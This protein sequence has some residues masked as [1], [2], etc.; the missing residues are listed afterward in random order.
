MIETYTPLSAVVPEHLWPEGLF[1]ADRES[2][3]DHL[4]CLVYDARGNDER[5]EVYVRI[6]VMKEARLPLPFLDGF[7]LVLGKGDTFETGIV[8]VEMIVE[9][10]PDAPP[11]IVVLARTTVLSLGID[12]RILEPVKI[13]YEGQRLK[14]T[15][16]GGHVAVPFP[17]ALR[18]E[19]V[20]EEWS[21]DF[22]L[23]LDETTSLS[24]P[25]C[26]IT[27]TNV[28]FEAAG[29]SLNL[30][31]NG[32]SPAGA[33]P[34][35]KGFYL[36]EAKIYLPD[37]FDG[38]ISATALGIGSG[39]FYG[40]VNATFA[41]TYAETASPRFSGD[42]VTTLLG[43]EGGISSVVLSFIQN[44][45]TAA[46]IKGKLLVPFFDSPLDVRMGF[47]AG[48]GLTVGLSSDQELR[49]FTKENVCELTLDGMSFEV[50]DGLFT[51]KLSGKLTPLFGKDKG[52]KWPTFDIKDLTI[53]SKGNVKLPG[54]WLSL[55]QQKTFDFYG[56]KIEIS[57]IGF[58]KN[59]DGS[60][61]IGFSGALKLVDGLQAGASVEGLR[62][63]WFEG[64]LANAKITLN[65]AGVELKI[66]GVLELKGSVSYR[67][68]K[69]GNEDIKRFDGD[70]QLKIKTPEMTVDGMMVIGSAKGPQGRYNFFAIYVDVELPTAIMLGSTG[71]AIYN[72]AGLF[73]LQMEP[74]K[75]AEEKWFSIDHGKSFYHRNKPG[76]TDLR[77]KWDPRKG[78]FAFGAG[79]KIG[80][81]A[82]DGYTFNGKFLLAIVL[83]G[84][85]ILLQGAS[86]F[87]TKN[88]E[89]EGQFRSLAVYDGRA[90]SFLIG[91]DAE[92]KTGKG[93]ELIEIAGSMEAYYSL[94]D[95]TAWHLWLGQRDPRAL[96]IR[97]ILGKFVEANAYFMLDARQLALGAW[98]GYSNGWNVG[99][100]SIRLEAWAEG[101]ALISFKPTHFHGDLWLHALVDLRVF[102]F[103][104]GIALDARIEADLFKPY[105]LRGEF[106]V[107]VKLPFRKKKIGAKVVLEWG[108][109]LTAPPLPLPLSQ[110]AV[111][112]L[113]TTTVWPL[114]RRKDNLP[115]YLLPNYDD[116]GG[117]YTSPSGSTA[118]DKLSGVPLVPL[119]SRIS[120]TFARSVHDLANVGSNLQPVN[121]A[122]E[123]VGHPG[124]PVVARVQYSLEA[125]ELS[126]LEA[127]DTWK[128]VAKSPQKDSTP[129]LY[130]QWAPVP[131]L[132]PGTPGQTKL[133]LWSK[134]AFD[135]TRATGSSWEEWVSDAWP[136][137]PCIPFVPGEEACFGFAGLAA[138]AEVKSPWTYAG[139]PRV[140]LSW[141][142]GPATVRERQIFM[143]DRPFPVRSLCFP[144]EVARRGVHVKCEPGQSVKIHLTPRGMTGGGL[145]R[146]GKDGGDVPFPSDGGWP[147]TEAIW[148]S[149]S[150]VTCVDVREEIA[151]TRMNPWTQEDL[152][153]AV[154]GADGTLLPQAR[155]E[156]W[157]TSPLGLNAGHR[158]DVELPCASPWVELIVTHR[159]PFRIV[160]FNGAGTAV[161][162]HTPA[163]AGV[164]TT[165][166]IRLEGEGITRL[167][168][169]AAGNEKLIHSVCYQC[170]RPSGPTGTGHDDDGNP[171]G[172]FVP[173]D[174]VIE[175]TG[176]EVTDVVVTSDASFCIDRIC[177]TPDVDAGQVMGRA[178]M[179]EHIRQELARWKS[180][181]ELLEP[182]T[183]YRLTVRTSIRPTPVKKITFPS[184][185]LLPVEH[186]YFRTG[187]PPGITRLPPPE[188]VKEENFDSGLDDL[189]RYVRETDPPTVPPPGEKPI[190]YE[191]F[192][193][194]YDL[195]VEFN[196]AYVGQMYRMDGRDLGLYVYDNSNQPARDVKG[197]LLALSNEWGVAEELTLSEKDTRW[198]TRIDNA[199]CLEEKLDPETF[200]RS[201]ALASVDP[202]RVLAPGT[203]YEARLVPLLLH[204][205]FARGDL[206]DV[207][208]GWLVEDSGAGGPSAWRA[209]ELGEPASRFVEQVSA[210]GGSALLF[211]AS[212]DWTDYRVTVYVQSP[213]RGAIGVVVRHQGPGT[214]Y[215]FTMDATHL[216]LTSGAATLREEHFAYQKNR[217]Y[218]LSVEVLGDMVRTYVD[219]EAVFEV[220]DAAHAQ[221]RIGL[222]VSGSAGARFTDVTVD[223]LRKTAPVAYRY[224]FTT[225][226]YANF[227][228][229]VHS[230]EDELWPADLATQ[231]VKTQLDEAIAPILDPPSEREARAYDELATLVLGE[232]VARQNPERV[233]IT[234]VTRTG[235]PPVYLLRSPE[236]IDHR[237][238]QFSAAR[239]FRALPAG[240][241][242][243]TLKLAEA[244]LDAALPADESVTLLLRD[245]AELTRHRVELRGLP[246]P[247]AEQV[248][249]PVLWVETFTRPESLE[250]FTFA[251]A[252]G[253]SAWK[254][255]RGAIV[256][257]S[258]T[259][260]GN[261]P[262]QPGTIAL[263][264]DVEWQDYRVTVDL[265][266]DA[267][268]DVGVVFRHRDADNHYRFSLGAASSY[269]RLVRCAGGVTTVLWEDAKGYT[270]G[271]TFRVAIVAIASS[272][273][274]FVDDVEIFG[275]V[276][277]THGAGR[278][279]IYAANNAGARCE[280]IEVRLPSIEAR[281]LF[282]D[283]FH[284]GDTAEWT[285]LS[286]ATGVPLAE[287]AHWQI[288]N[289]ALRLDS[290]VA[291]GAYA[292]AGDSSWADVILQARVRSSGGMAGVLIRAKDPANGYRFSMSAS[293]ERQLVRRVDG[294]TTI[295]WRDTVAYQANRWYEVTISAIGGTLRGFID[296]IPLFAVDDGDLAD[297]GVGLFSS[298][299][300]QA[301]F[302]D[303]HVWPGTQAFSGWSF[304]EH[305]AGLS[306]DRWSF[307]GEH[308]E[309][310]AD[311]WNVEDG[312]LR[313]ADENVDIL[314]VF[315]DPL[316]RPS[317]TFR[318]H[319]AI[320]A[321]PE[322]AGMRLLARLRLDPAGDAG[323]VF[324][325]R[326]AF[327]HTVLWL[328][329]GVVTLVR[330]A[331]GN[332]ETLVSFGLSIDHTTE[333]VVAIDCD[334]GRIAASIDG[335]VLFNFDAA[336]SAG[337]FGFAVMALPTFIVAPQQRFRELL[338]AEPQWTTLY[339]FPP[340]ERLPAGTRVHVHASSPTTTAAEAGRVTRSVA[341]AGERGRTRMR[342]SQAMLRLVGPDGAS[343]HMRGFIH[344]AG[345]VP[346]SVKLL[347][348]ADG[349]AFFLIPEDGQATNPLRVTMT[350]HRDRPEAGRAMSQAGDRGV[351]QGTVVLR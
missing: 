206:A 58:G 3:L 23:P 309:A 112:H 305:F 242:P 335:G 212:A 43:M 300:Q 188:G 282:R 42:L 207:P 346:I 107:G 80:T 196:E 182:H 82:D 329:R 7:A 143:E 191:P 264:G 45:P 21:L 292:M 327:N 216:R 41:L 31:G 93:G 279:G 76:I 67:E 69:I 163:A 108:P 316:N 183:T 177:V 32:A 28:I 5:L 162:T 155:I 267:G 176:D 27:D 133:M 217:D 37:L 298:S 351:E 73:A 99:P 337:R 321:G 126:R 102:G 213:V 48:G 150:S 326:D 11:S 16:L 14:V 344:E 85:I 331:G 303:V 253:P 258:G 314:N 72:I 91:L 169:H 319:Y 220:Q 312:T 252:A 15:P 237:R 125:L 59:D 232:P 204:E 224:Q 142:F 120:V 243:Q 254:W 342:G 96:R 65:G 193:R 313:P 234:R 127:N 248:G 145:R 211:G 170:T 255:E 53:D 29:V 87:L 318:A 30:S 322:I 92:Y 202:D 49:R 340:E 273:T 158:L 228:H 241:P 285:L 262:E 56:F 103:G 101:N 135:F 347:R 26:R 160:A 139:P 308:G 250:R 52:L 187:G 332:A 164:Q 244:T 291:E 83:P 236:P 286:E 219:G 90:G 60:K 271:E 180:T 123:E 166:T 184:G 281:A 178:E 118:P 110:V 179:I 75:K 317:M 201:S 301:W 320:A 117:F 2:F 141:G 246:G 330:T 55:A 151:G 307:V 289:G 310:E 297:G 64:D 13:E 51:T 25:P 231:D 74:N 349:T 22:D 17:F 288:D 218:R 293:G 203:L 336:L 35:W 165:E 325:W 34:G 185:P 284:R 299:N 88:D 124:G 131:Q 192:Y 140:T 152:R 157:G 240:E 186:A 24:I 146:R 116:G 167:E 119:D 272:I 189:V 36:G 256:E 114:P 230:F 97:A 175:V 6:K 294:T 86:S 223:D 63:T 54:G 44:I 205:T 132:G 171:Y 84:P 46:A 306:A 122:E 345:W 111:E 9:A 261:E 296:G 238:T 302:S 70:I 290:L 277:D 333:H 251:D 278:V 222:Y 38:S 128:L 247:V 115:K 19:Y 105:H 134:S 71:L 40:S 260:G 8:D 129:P 214:G 172:P 239:S 61:W 104:F 275:V 100:L 324:G 18:L 33:P 221:G 249:D 348:K 263:A 215:R 343:G 338:L 159:P 245:S 156:R 39:G 190:L 50:N 323:I 274:A 154:R 147:V 315:R 106:S 266:G 339:A 57:Q 287:A 12:D 153:F 78:S 138:G 137:Y 328:G 94:H 235:A 81:Y 98:F 295:L 334:G 173:V 194:A 113:K 109:R 209:G 199:T 148:S 181:G 136:D 47:D 225:S 269:R 161:A 198:I 174:D 283:A 341:A 89:N 4:A 10:F 62:I 195:G 229:H 270:A 350:F 66:P 130:G 257:T 20:N 1:G 149:G 79:M 304:E 311:R 210:I 265:R 226:R 233:E 280:Q 259:G 200:P 144:E 121:P 77:N 68:M 227:F 268:G 208:P 197:R 276:D 168:V 95:P